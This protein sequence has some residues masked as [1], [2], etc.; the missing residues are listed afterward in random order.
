MLGRC[1][2]V[3]M[4][5]ALIAL[6]VTGV[7]SAHAILVRTEPSDGAVLG[8][9]PH[10]VQ[11]WFSEA[12]LLNFT[13]MKLM[14]GAG[15]ETALSN[16]RS[17]PGDPKMLV[18]DLPDLPPGV[19]RLT[20]S[21]LSD[22]DLHSSTGSIVF[23]V[24]QAADL[25][26]AAASA[27]A[28]QFSEVALRW[29]NFLAFAGLIGSLAGALVVLPAA[30]A[31]PNSQDTSSASWPISQLR[32]RLL[33]LALW[34]VGLALIVG[35]G[36]VFIQ[37]N[38]DG[39]TV[40]Q[41]LTQTSYG[42]HWLMRQGWLIVIMLILILHLRG[43]LLPDAS[44]NIL[45]AVMAPLIAALVI[46][47]TL[48]GHAAAAS[49]AAFMPVIVD[50]LH[51]LAASVWVGGLSSLAITIVPLLRR[52]AAE[53]ALARSILQ[54][55]SVLA[56][57]SVAVLAITGLLNSGEQV[58]SLDALLFTF[59]GQALLL[60]LA[61]VMGVAL[62]ALI[63]SALVH[64]RVADLIRRVLRRPIGWTLLPARFLWRTIILESIGATIVLL[65]AALLSA[66]PPARGPEFDPPVAEVAAVPDIS[67]SV[68]DLLVAF[69]IKPNHPGQNFI[70]VGV[71]NTRRPPP[72]PIERVTVKLT[73][74][75]GSPATLIATT[76]ENGRYEFP[77]DAITSTGDWQVS[78]IVTRPNLPDAVLNVPWR[79]TPLA[80]AARVRPVVISNRPL[81]PWT[82][83]L[84]ILMGAGL[85]IGLIAFGV[86]RAVRVT[87]LSRIH[88][89]QPLPMAH[90]E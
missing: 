11:L 65:F 10:Q 37:A 18:V 8:Q 64:P 53:K 74:P 68:A 47:Q 14:D 25:A 89:A 3:W 58:A 27:A 81:A 4:L 76:S 54:R 86:R 32:R 24:Q 43:Q 78:V 35:S 55:F 60:K 19:Y 22:D 7:A 20:W 13:S 83:L 23:G 1:I 44:S 42:A 72:A 6:G 82:I 21:T 34:S 52:S 69:S 39:N 40:L 70:D 28:P 38:G 36:L 79:V 73:P 16:I 84:A 75:L 26:P 9:P 41:V 88:S 2:R 90:K 77:S 30:D 67:T 50:A 66:S 71:F 61:L 87:V 59:Y 46:S 45:L 12:V 15:R 85:S 33:K 57:S 29:L 80:A 5:V 31:V 56:V 62:I 51:L 49:D 48:T 63:N 17:D